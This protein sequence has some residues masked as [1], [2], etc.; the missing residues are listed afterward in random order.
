MSS[1]ALNIGL[2]DSGASNLSSFGITLLDSAPRL[3]INVRVHNQT[4]RGETWWIVENNET[5]VSYRLDAKAYAIVERLDGETP[6]S[7][8]LANL[9][10]QDDINEQQALALITQLQQAGLL[11]GQGEY[12]DGQPGLQKPSAKWANKF[13]NPLAVRIPLWDPDRFLTRTTPMLDRCITHFSIAALAL[14]V[15]AG[16]IVACQQF[17]ALSNY[18]LSRAGELS[19]LLLLVMT[20]PFIK[21]IHELAHAFS[22]KRHG[23]EVH[24][25]GIMCLVFFPVP[26]VDASASA[27]FENKQHRIEVASAGIVA[28][29]VLAAL[30]ILVWANIQQGIVSDIA[31]SIALVGSISTVLFNGNPLL[32]FDGYFVLSDW[33]EIPNLASRARSYCLYLVRRFLLGV[34]ELITPVTARGERRWFVS[35][36]IAS[37]VYRLTVMFGIAVYLI[38]MMPL[39]GGLLALLAVTNQIILPT[40]KC[41]NY[42]LTDSELVA[43]R[44]RSIGTTVLVMCAMLFGVVFIPL[45][46]WTTLPGVVRMPEASI[47]RASESGFVRKL[48]AENGVMVAAGQT[49]AV[50]ENHNLN[51]E[52]QRLT[53]RLKELEGRR[54]AVVL[55]SP[56]EAAQ[57][58]ESISATSLEIDSVNR[59]I[60]NHIVTAPTSGQLQYLTN[61]DWQG[62][63]LQQGDTL[64][65]VISNNERKILTVAPESLI[66]EI[67]SPQVSARLRSP[68]EPATSLS[69]QIVSVT[70]AGS[71]DL[72]DAALGSNHGGSIAVDSRDSSG[73]HALQQTFQIELVP[74]AGEKLHP[75]SSVQVRFDLPASSLGTQ[76][77]AGLARLLMKEIQW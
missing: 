32:R 17:T 7:K 50:L 8:I 16:F 1:N 75:G 74:S 10:M 71:R 72:P 5:G 42:L 30:A 56:S 15:L 25:L 26:Y 46:N 59:R 63:F 64:A 35:Y 47:V 24:E 51:K 6:V 40:F 54:A 34:E 19:S 73:K 52:A 3:R 22:I 11:L 62:R 43:H 33:L 49:I 70:P 66:A 18:G 67:R 39:F 27:A 38:Q 48:V 44:M 31:F 2:P 69:A 21:G 77:H 55:E 20:Y 23:G 61:A 60:N 65:H 36:F 57:F 9:S 28:E 68:A 13:K 37:S 76:I 14:I 45:P 53:W 58:A 29:L 41:V 12:L 4:S